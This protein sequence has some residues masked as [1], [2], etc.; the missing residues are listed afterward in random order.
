MFTNNINSL[1]FDHQI[2]REFWIPSMKVELYHEKSTV[3]ID[4]LPISIFKKSLKFH[5]KEKQH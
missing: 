2:P 3:Q 1:I 4:Q 5:E